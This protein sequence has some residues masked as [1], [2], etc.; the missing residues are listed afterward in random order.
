[1]ASLLIPGHTKVDLR[2]HERPTYRKF[3]NCHHAMRCGARNKKSRLRRQASA[4]AKAREK[5]NWL[6]G[7]F[8]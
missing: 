3:Q 8:V 6:R 5:M 7:A 2:S 4:A 1:M